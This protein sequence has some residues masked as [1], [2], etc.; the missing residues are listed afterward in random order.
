[1]PLMLL[2]P[3]FPLATVLMGMIVVTSFKFTKFEFAD[4]VQD[5]ADCDD[6]CGVLCC[7]CHEP[8]T[9]DNHILYDDSSESFYAYAKK[10]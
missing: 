9:V 2:L 1:M 3:F 8:P 4:I 7:C 5:T 10:S 6:E